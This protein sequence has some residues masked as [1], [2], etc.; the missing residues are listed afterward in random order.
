VPIYEY[1]CESCGRL[2]EVMQ[3]M[4]DPAPGAC[5][6][7][8]GGKLAKLVSRTTF[9]LKGGGWYSDLYASPKK[10]ADKPAPDAAKGGEAK[11]AE[12]K[13]ATADAPAPK[14]APAA[15]GDKS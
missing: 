4:N 13:P 5:P 2:T 10:A 9:Q 1:V 3:K 11:P 8:G 12:A 7:C 14:A 6:E 15:G